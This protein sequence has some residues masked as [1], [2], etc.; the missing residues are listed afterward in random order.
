MPEVLNIEMTGTSSPIF[1]AHSP[2][3][4]GADL[5]EMYQPIVIVKPEMV[6]IH[7]EAR[8]DSFCKLEGGEGLTIGRWVHIAS[9]CH[10]NIGGGEVIFEEGSAAAS[11]AKIIGG[12]NLP[13]GISMSAKAPREM[14]QTKR[15]R[16]II[17]KNAIVFSNAVVMPGVTV[18]EGAVVAAGAV[19]TKDIPPF[20][21]WAGVPARKIGQREV[22]PEEKA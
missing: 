22:L 2:S 11:G 3:A 12:S 15:S 9:F 21:I 20:E 17:G 13:S 10:I 14:Q 19:A 4:I 18:G 8:I 7:P 1:V 16:T 5:P 6:H